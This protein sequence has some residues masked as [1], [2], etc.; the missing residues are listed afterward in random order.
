VS[1]IVVVDVDPRRGGNAETFLDRFPTDMIVQ[2][3][4]GG[5]HLYY[6]YPKSVNHL[7]NRVDF[8]PGLDLRADGGMVVAPPSIHESGRDYAWLRRGAPAMLPNV[9]ARDIIQLSANEKGWITKLLT[10]GA[11]DGQRND[12]CAKLAGYFASVNAPYDVTL[13]TLLLWNERNRPP[14]PSQEVEKTV[15]SV[16]QTEHR[17]KGR[18]ENSPSVART[19]SYDGF[20]LMTFDNYMDVYSNQM[21]NWTVDKWLPVSTMAF[22]ISPPGG[23]KTWLTFDLAISIATGTPFL[24]KFKVHEPGPVFLVQQ[25]DFHGQTQTRLDIITRSRFKMGVSDGDDFEIRTPPKIPIFI[26]PDRK[27]KFADK[28]AVMGLESAI[29]DIRPKLVIID[30]LYSAG[31]TQDYMAK[32]ATQ[33]LALKTFRDRYNCSFLIVHHTKKGADPADRERLWGSSFLNAFIETGWQVSKS[34][35]AEIKVKRHFKSA[36]N[37]D[38]TNIC[39]DIDTKDGALFYKPTV[40]N[41]KDVEFE[42]DE[43]EI[44]PMVD[45]ATLPSKKGPKPRPVINKNE[46]VIR[47]NTAIDN[48][49]QIL[50]TVEEA[51][52]EGITFG[53]LCAKLLPMHPTTV[54]RHLRTYQELGM[55]GRGKD[56]STYVVGEF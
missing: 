42:D 14:L 49:E 50:N 9:F 15:E 8:E 22:L 26:H 37:A 36:E 25:E 31:D 35:E 16:F 32:T 51:G 18:Q 34:G 27:L 40:V 48:K 6:R 12:A 44:E 28:T 38:S 2:T 54:R 20:N 41:D 23:F 5:Q 21:V 56:A 46:F 11:P 13:A 1:N 4:G 33:M 3:G 43:T 29:E 10:T 47:R 17:R 45:K 7:P 30:P 19:H 24:N 55:V 53:D 52:E 39:F